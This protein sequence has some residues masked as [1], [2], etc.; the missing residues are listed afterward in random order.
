M[1]KLYETWPGTNRFLPCGC[2]IGPAGDMC[3][4]LCIYVCMLGALI[5]YCIFMLPK[6]WKA[7]P[8]LPIVFLVSLAATV[9]FLNLTQCSDPGIIPRR[10][11]LLK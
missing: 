9:L 3:A 11:Y 8:A 10:P 6:I 2:T 5:P 4:N 1:P 7:S